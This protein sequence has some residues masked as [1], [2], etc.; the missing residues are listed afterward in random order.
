MK[1][2]AWLS[3]QAGIAEQSYQGY[4]PDK[5]NGWPVSLDEEGVQALVSAEDALARIARSDAPNL[6]NVLA[7]W[8]TARD[9]SIYSSII[10]GIHS[11][12][13]A[14]MWAQ[15]RQSVQRPVSDQNEALTLGAVRQNQAAVDLGKKIRAGAQCTV[16]DITGLHAKLFENTRSQAIG[17]MIRDDP[18]W[19]GP[20]GST[21]DFA[22]FVAPPPCLVPELLDDLV[23]YINSTVHT[24][25]LQSALAYCQFETIHPFEDGNGRTGRALI[26]TILNA[27]GSVDGVLPISFCLEQDR[28][29]HYGALNA[30][31]VI[32]PA[33]DWQTRNR[34]IV[35]W[36]QLFSDACISAEHQIAENHQEA[37][38][39]VTAWQ[40]KIRPY[41]GTIT[42]ALVA[43]LPSMPVFDSVLASQRLG[44]SKPAVRASIRALVRAGVVQPAG[45]K[46]N[47]RFLVPEIINRLRTAQPDGGRRLED[48]AAPTM[49]AAPSFTTTILCGHHGK[50]SHRACLLP[51]GHAGHHRYQTK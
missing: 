50:R 36:L 46:R 48:V 8:M 27:R 9:E 29:E 18:I 40:K 49:P 32:C 41:T 24:S 43:A 6:G 34:S 4:V 44:V 25:C 21:I 33:D 7:G 30:T 31:R 42:E 5:L 26:Q 22:S 3:T 51:R 17:G 12:R 38:A 11:S 39:L 15:Y 14:L 37:Q 20:P 10:E 19:V 23:G 35:R 16:D 28:R 2:Q 13:N 1:S 45:G 47:G